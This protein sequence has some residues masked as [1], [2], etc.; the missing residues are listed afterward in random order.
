M[1]PEVECFNYVYDPGEVSTLWDGPD[2]NCVISKL[3]TP[4]E[5]K[6]KEHRKAELR[7]LGFKRML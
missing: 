1:G 4:E 3:D 2:K 6:E 5:V 7:K